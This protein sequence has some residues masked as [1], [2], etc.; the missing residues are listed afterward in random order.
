MALN[1]M[2]MGDVT[3]SD[4]SGLC[5]TEKTWTIGHS[6]EPGVETVLVVRGDLICASDL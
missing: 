3:Y 4:S 5:R 2:G 1:S 6:P